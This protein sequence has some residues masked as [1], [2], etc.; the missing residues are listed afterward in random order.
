MENKF[1]WADHTTASESFSQQKWMKTSGK[2]ATGEKT[3]LSLE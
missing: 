2:Q 3:I 1:G